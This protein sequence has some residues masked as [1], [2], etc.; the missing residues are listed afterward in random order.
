M[1]QLKLEKNLIIRTI[2]KEGH[3]PYK[4][5]VLPKTKAKQ[6]IVRLY[7]NPTSRHLGLKRTLE[8]ARQQLF[9]PGMTRDVRKPV[10]EFDVCTSSK[11]M[12]PTYISPLPQEQTFGKFDRVDIDFVGQFPDKKQEQVYLSNR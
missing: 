1:K 7:S 10:T 8:R 2:A 9:Y 11:Q 4:Q 6:F 5:A 12:K 3:T